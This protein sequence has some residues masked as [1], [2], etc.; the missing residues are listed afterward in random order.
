MRFP[1]SFLD[2]IRDRVRVSEVVG[3]RVAWDKRKSQPARG[4]YWACCPF[5][6]E[7]SPSFHADDRR[8]HYHCFGCGASGDHFTF[9]IEK[10]GMSF[11]EA[12]ELLAA[13]AG[14]PMPERDARDEERQAER[15]SL[16]DVL[17]KAARFF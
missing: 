11:P 15:A 7:R 9:L 5:H 3:R 17:E 1:P 12:V 8:G 14:V 6:D 10:E 4:D 16:H 2:Q 13:E